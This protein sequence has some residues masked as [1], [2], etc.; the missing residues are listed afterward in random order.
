[1]HLSADGEIIVIHD[2][3]LDRTTNGKGAVNQY[4]IP[5]RLKNNGQQT[6]PTLTEVF[7]LIDKNV[8]SISN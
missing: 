1:V 5:K 2:E 8:R 4:T 7:D 3:T 6:I